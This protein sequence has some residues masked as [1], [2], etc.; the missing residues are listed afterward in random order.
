MRKFWLSTLSLSLILGGCASGAAFLSQKT[1]APQLQANSLRPL[2][3]NPEQQI[4]PSRM[5]A[6]AA[7]LTG[8]KPMP[9][10]LTIP[11][12]GTTQG[13]DLTRKFI[14]SVLESYGYKPELHNYRSSG[15]NIL[16]R[17]MAEQP[18]QEYI[19]VGAHLD[20]VRNAGADDN[21]SGTVAVLEAARVLKNLQGRKL[22]LIFAWFDEE[23]LGLVGSRY[24]AKDLKKQGLN[25][26]SVHTLDMVGWDSD[27]DRVIEIEQPDG[28]LWDYYQMVNK[29]HQLNLPLS[30]TS[31][32]DT[33]HVAFRN[34]GFT[35]VGLCE[36]WVGGD[37]TP[38][39]H[40]RTDTYTT[41]DFGYLHKVSQLMVA[42][43]GDLVRAVPAPL[44]QSRVPH[45]RF[46]GRARPSHTSYDEFPL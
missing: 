10:G 39:Y 17:L 26:T 20:S 38:Y 41:L 36:E 4:E 13:R 21:N 18:T 19:L 14:M 28:P 8:Q 22:N 12:R 6:L 23:E 16:V 37:T 45:D 29:S 5:E 32:G 46:P 1:L 40:R 2:N 25:I 11:E 15:S 34:E 7:V 24:L 42:A 33:D 3:N 31:S 27:K 44:I 43:I 35:S 30:R 9:D